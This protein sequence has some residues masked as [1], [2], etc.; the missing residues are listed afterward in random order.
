MSK[1]V[2]VACADQTHMT[3]FSELAK[4]VMEQYG[5]SELWRCEVQVDGQIF[6][7]CSE[8]SLGQVEGKMRGKLSARRVALLEQLAVID[9]ALRQLDEEA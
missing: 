8:G 5:A 9:E 1:T 7:A 3:A 4:S 2:V 6:E